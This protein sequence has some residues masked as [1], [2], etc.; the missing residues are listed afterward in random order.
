MTAAEWE[1]SHDPD[2]M[3][4]AAGK[5]LSDRSLLLFACGA[6]RRVSDLLP[7]FAATLLPRVEDAADLPPVERANALRAA[8]E[9]I[10][11]MTGI[12]ARGFLPLDR[13]AVAVQHAAT[14]LRMLELR[15]SAP[16][17]TLVGR[18]FSLLESINLVHLPSPEQA[19]ILRCV[20]GNP[21]VK[22]K[23][24][25]VWRTSDVLALARAADGEHAFDN[26]PILADALQDAGC[27]DEMLL[28][29]LR[30]DTL[31]VRG[32]RALDRILGK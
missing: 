10:E 5:R 8:F 16:P 30:N 27:G 17:R 31:H 13:L 3:L 25:P 24:K 1:A 26:F 12:F 7:E 2:K 6:A 11:G 18:A 20:A 9:S 28:N 32:C 22:T 29:H 14:T 23:F 21:F 19:A 4:S 15:R